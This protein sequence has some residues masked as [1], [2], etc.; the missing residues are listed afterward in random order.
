MD[1][2]TLLIPMPELNNSYPEECGLR[3][4]ES[5][6]VIYHELNNIDMDVEMAIWKINFMPKV[7][8]LGMGFY[9]SHP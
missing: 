3:D 6:P 2:W 5:L 8:L 7:F 4:I 9:F 1:F